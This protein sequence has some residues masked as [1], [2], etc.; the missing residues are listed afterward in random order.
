M[1]RAANPAIRTKL[2]ER[3]V[4]YVLKQGLVDLSLR[5]LAAA[6]DTSPRML[7]Y[8]FG[9]KERLII[10]ALAQARVRQEQEFVR[11]LSIRGNRSDRLTLAWEVWSLEENKQFLWF[12]FEVY[13]LAMRNRR[14]F[15]G[16]LERMVKDWLT[17]FEQAVEAAGVGPK[18]VT[19]LATFILATIRGLQLD[20]LA[21][22]EKPRVDAAFQ[23][24]L[25]LLSL[26]RPL[27]TGKVG[28][29]STRKTK[30][31]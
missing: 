19:P 24:M 31:N 10:E 4:D 17:F 12:F 8:F 22:G 23:E 30:R 13:A 5:P 14:R 9:S 3:T 28:Q 29:Q 27:A 6:L 2:L 15:P 18:R 11:L 26:P 25:Q 16:Y 20:L 21:T 1:T 7:L